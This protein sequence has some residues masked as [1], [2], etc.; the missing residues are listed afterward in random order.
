MTP[1][2]SYYDRLVASVG[3]IA[4]HAYYPGVEQTLNQCLEDIDALR[5]AD[6]ITPEQREALRF[7]VLGVSLHAA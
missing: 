2:L 4:R 7:I 5:T 6:Q 3:R 1:S